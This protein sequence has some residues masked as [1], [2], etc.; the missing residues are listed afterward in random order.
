MAKITGIF[1]L[2]ATDLQGWTRV[3]SKP[4]AISQFALAELTP[5]GKIGDVIIG[6]GKNEGFT[7]IL[8]ELVKKYKIKS[9]QKIPRGFWEELASTGMYGWSA[10]KEGGFLN[11]QLRYHLQKTIAYV[12]SGQTLPGAMD[13]I[14]LLM[15]WAE[16]HINKDNSVELLAK[17]RGF[18]INLIYSSLGAAKDSPQKQARLGRLNTLLRSGLEIGSVEQGA[19]LS[20]IKAMWEDTSLVPK[21]V[22]AKEIEAAI[23]AGEKKVGMEVMKPYYSLYDMVHDVKK[24]AM[25]ADP[26]KIYAG[27]GGRA[28]EELSKVRTEEGIL[29]LQRK[30]STEPWLERELAAHYRKKSLEIRNVELEQHL[31]FPTFEKVAG[32]KQEQ[33]ASVLGILDERQHHALADI[34]TAAEL[35]TG[36]KGRTDLERTLL[37][38]PYYEFVANQR[39]ASVAAEKLVKTGTQPVSARFSMEVL[40]AGASRISPRSSPLP[41]LALGGGLLLASKIGDKFKPNPYKQFG[42]QIRGY[43]EGIR[44]P[45]TQWDTIP[46]IRPSPGNVSDFS[47]GRDVSRVLEQ[48]GYGGVRFHPGLWAAQMRYTPDVQRAA[49]YGSKMTAIPSI[50]KPTDSELRNQQLELADYVMFMEDADTVTLQR[51]W[52]SR[53]MPVIGPAMGSLQQGIMNILPK[54]LADKMMGGFQ[55]RLKGIDAPELGEKTTTLGSQPFAEES[56]DIARSILSE[57]T[58]VDIDLSQST[59][60]RYVGTFKSGT[61][62]LNR[63]I[64]EQGGAMGSRAYMAAEYTAQSKEAGIWQSPFY[65][66][67]RQGNE[68]VEE[69][70]LAQIN[71]IKSLSE[72]PRN[73]AVYSAGLWA[74]MTPAQKHAMRD[75]YGQNAHLFPGIYKSRYT[76]L[77][78]YNTGSIT[79]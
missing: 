41:L 55:V 19:Y 13:Q 70:G 51:A 21:Y 72:K 4:P 52:I 65:F 12:N 49:E 56:L 40:Q 9:V 30:A 2:E 11:K 62:D 37:S 31:T 42:E 76:D 54:K 75:P 60:G 53:N 77:M 7:D 36:F 68:Q 64:V 38:D 5:E 57:A 71:K 26:K 74:L 1:D 17:S 14:D 79:S 73:M 24:V 61:R 35:T 78:G 67:V 39:L 22:G 43:I 25:G 33:L 69:V 32:Q 10:F 58:T 3:S 44:K 16:G 15:N 45:I 59:F 6:G 23:F 46:G 50:Y 34:S 18:D 20:M 28:L 66:G 29:A 27:M 48:G 63:E 8:V 47:S